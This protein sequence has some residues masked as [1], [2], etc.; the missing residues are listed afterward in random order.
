[1][2]ETSMVNYASL[3]YLLNEVS[4]YAIR[5]N[6]NKKSENQTKTD[7]LKNI[8][9]VNNPKT[10]SYINKIGFNVGF[11]STELLLIDPS[12]STTSLTNVSNNALTENPLEAM[13]FICRDV[14]K[15]IFGKQMDNLR[16]NH[17]GTFV[18]VDHKPISYYNCYYTTSTTT[19]TTGDHA[20]NERAAP[21][22][23]F[24]VG[25][26]YGVLACLGVVVVSVTASP[27]PVTDD[28]NQVSHDNRLESDDVIHNSVLYTV[29]TK[30]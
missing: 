13:K 22:L 6:I 18:L 24:N 4:S 8:E 30:N 16:T 1:M 2:T 26:I 12:I 10:L 28:K 11:K 15:N 17:V 20:T 14:W 9:D 19:S 23:E 7:Y 3:Q 29:E 5:S 27:A 25:L 21:F